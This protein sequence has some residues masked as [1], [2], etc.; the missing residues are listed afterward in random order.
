MMSSSWMWIKVCLG[1]G[2]FWVTVDQACSGIEGMVVSLSITAIYLFLSR[3]FLRFPQA[4]LLLPLA[5]VL[6]AL[7]NVFRIVLLV[8]I[9]AEWLPEIAV[10]GFHSVAGW[11]GT[12]LVALLIVFVF[13]SW[14]WVRRADNRLP[15]A[16]AHD[17]HELVR[18]ILIPFVVLLSASL[19][20]K[21][22]VDEFNILYPV[23]AGMTSI[24]LVL[25]WHR[26]TP[27]IARQAQCC[28]CN[29]CYGCSVLD[30]DIH[31]RAAVSSGGLGCPFRIA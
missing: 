13:S 31:W 11:L 7:L 19:V 26:L 18:A 10:K 15:V 1:A 24:A 2:E 17:D 14:Q 27:S 28:H 12:V 16:V 30:C 8:I 9:G 29:G 25:V 5:C 6:S 3:D 22:L 21:I 23:V 20:V 4:L